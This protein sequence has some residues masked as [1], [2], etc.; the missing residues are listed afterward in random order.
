MPE[1]PARGFQLTAHASAQPVE[2]MP[3][4]VRRTLAWGDRMLLVE[5]AMKAGGVVP[6]HSHLHE[7]IGYLQA[8]R[9]VF[10]VGD[11][12]IVVNA[13]DGYTIAGGESHSARAEVDS[14]A[15]EVFSPV[16]EEYK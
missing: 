9:I 5:V 10:T 12:D 8:G 4:I 13:G 2:M 6:L 3:G 7:Q 14:V 15:V 16:R 11:R 1:Q